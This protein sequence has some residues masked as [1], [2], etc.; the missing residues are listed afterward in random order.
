M[1]RIIPTGHLNGTAESELDKQYQ[2]MLDGIDVMLR[3]ISDA[4][5]H[6]RDYYVQG[7]YAYEAAREQHQR[8]WQTLVE[9][10]AEITEDFLAF[11]QSTGR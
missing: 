8:R 5:P 10:K 3:A 1:K 4:T 6:G 11:L 7:T 2:Q 9:L